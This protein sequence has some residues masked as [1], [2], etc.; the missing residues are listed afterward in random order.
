MK[1]S[2]IDVDGN[3]YSVMGYVSRAMKECGK[4]KMEITAYFDDAKSADY[5][6]LLVV[7]DAMIERLNAEAGN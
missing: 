7:S 1:Y 6:H 5:N 4:P 3:A 2:L